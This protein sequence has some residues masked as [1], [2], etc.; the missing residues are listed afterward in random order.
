MLVLLAGLLCGER[1]YERCGALRFT[2]CSIQQVFVH[3]YAL[4]ISLNQQLKWYG[5]PRT[6]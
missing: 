1:R 2:M 3:M 6:T 5:E 4:L